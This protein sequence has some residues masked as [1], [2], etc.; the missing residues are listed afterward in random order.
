MQSP[1]EWKNLALW[2]IDCECSSAFQ[3]LTTKSTAKHEKRRHVLICDDLQ[4]MLKCG[5]YFGHGPSDQDAVERRL[6]N[7]SGL[8]E[9][10]NNRR[11][12]S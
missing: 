4:K 5:V 2:L 11:T 3:A 7:L 9:Y 12:E 6:N 8:Q 1:E 10:A